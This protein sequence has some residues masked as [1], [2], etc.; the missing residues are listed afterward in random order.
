MFVEFTIAVPKLYKQYDGS[1]NL[2]CWQLDE[3]DEELRV[4]LER[5]EV[6]YKHMA[7]DWGIAYSWEDGVDECGLQVECVDAD[8]SVY[9]VMAW[10]YR[11]LWFFRKKSVDIGQT[12]LG[13]VLEDVLRMGVDTPC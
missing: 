9:R 8:S 4:I 2:C 12:R 10:A 6:A 11:R 13:Q 3:F 5:R 7:E 1:D